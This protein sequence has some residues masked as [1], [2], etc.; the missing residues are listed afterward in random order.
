MTGDEVS[1]LGNSILPT[2]KTE[3][4]ICND[5][6]VTKVACKA[7][8]QGCQCGW[9]NKIFSTLH[10]TRVV[11]HI[12]KIKGSNIAT[13]QAII[14]EEHQ[15]HYQA[16]RDKSISRSSIHA[17]VKNAIEEL[18]DGCQEL[19]TD[20]FMSACGTLS[21]KSPKTPTIIPYITLGKR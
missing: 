14:L 8:K 6:Y 17:K 18:I 9:C 2:P 7:E 20:L 11:C 15:E 3:E 5:T 16:M 4:Q 21:K 10:A 19:G 13:C 12:L 1:Q